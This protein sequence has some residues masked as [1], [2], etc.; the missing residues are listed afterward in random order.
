MKKHILITVIAACLTLCAVV[1][2]QSGVVEKIPESTQE[3]VVSVPETPAT[4]PKEEVEL[5]TPSEKE[6][7]EPQQLELPLETVSDLESV[8]VETPIVP[9]VQSTLETIPAS[10]SVPEPAP[11]QTAT[12][13]HSGDMV[14]VPGFGWLESQG[15]GAA[16]YDDMMYENGNKVG[17]MD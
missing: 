17:S 16:I 7:T 12:I 4:T 9:K 15:E 10:E 3:G 8:P 13:P 14:Y 6:N 1:W 2:L 11:P 5:L